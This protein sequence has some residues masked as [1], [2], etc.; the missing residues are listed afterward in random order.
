MANAHVLCHPPR[1]FDPFRCLDARYVWL[2]NHTHATFLLGVVDVV[3]LSLNICWKRCCWYR[4]LMFLFSLNVF[5]FLLSAF[6]EHCF[7]F[8]MEFITVHV[9]TVHLRVVVVNVAILY[10]YGV[11]NRKPGCHMCMKYDR[12]PL[13]TVKLF[14]ILNVIYG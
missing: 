8:R 6:F 12:W 4:Y 7:L 11:L 14:D 2:W 9:S 1:W 10:T 13:A 5:F 3:F